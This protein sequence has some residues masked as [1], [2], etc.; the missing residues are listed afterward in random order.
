MNEQIVYTKGLS[1]II[2]TFISQVTMNLILALIVFFMAK[3]IH[4]ECPVDSTCRVD[5]KGGNNM[6]RYYKWL[7]ETEPPPNL[8][9]P[10]ELNY[11]C[12]QADSG[13]ICTFPQ[14]SKAQGYYQDCKYHIPKHFSM[15]FLKK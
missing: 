9:L 5:F 7:P 6:Q 10:D 13:S 12:K 15:P 2:Y 4:A 14:D 3:S 11:F 8:F 1:F